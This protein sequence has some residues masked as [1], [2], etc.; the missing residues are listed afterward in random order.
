MENEEIDLETSEE[1][2][3]V[4]LTVLKNLQ[5]LFAKKQQ[6]YTPLNLTMNVLTG[7]LSI[8]MNNLIDK[9]KE[10]FIMTVALNLTLNLINQRKN[11]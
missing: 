9:D 3:K 10:E 7:C 6:K 4:C 11:E 1:V 5:T 8:I 2:R